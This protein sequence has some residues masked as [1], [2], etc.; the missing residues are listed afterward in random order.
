MTRL[1]LAFCFPVLLAAQ[2]PAVATPKL[3]PPEGGGFRVLIVPDM[4]GMGSAVDI[5][6]VIAGNE[7]E[8]YRTLTS[9]DYWPWVLDQVRR[10]AGVQPDGGERCF[11]YR[12]D[13]AEEVGNLLNKIEWIVLK[14]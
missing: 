6:E 14:P 3:P 13:S 12:T 9:D 1:L 7:G 10:L 5:H 2:T 4:E 8:Q 11:A